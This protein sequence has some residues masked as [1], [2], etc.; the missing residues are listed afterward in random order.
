[1]CLKRQRLT[2]QS[3]GMCIP[4]FMAEVASESVSTNE[5]HKDFKKLATAMILNCWHQ[6]G[7]LRENMGNVRK[8]RVF[9]ALLGEGHRYNFGSRT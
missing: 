3:W 5:Y 8:L 2:I 1:M 4:V 7:Y 9:G 6:I